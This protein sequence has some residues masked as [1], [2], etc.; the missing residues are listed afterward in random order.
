MTRL[1]PPIAAVAA[2][3]LFVSL[4]M[5]QLDRAAQKE[6]L[7]SLYANDAPARNLADVDEPLQFERVRAQGVL[8]A[9]RQIL[10]DYYVITPL[11]FRRDEPLLLVNRGWIERMAYESGAVELDLDA[12]RR[13]LA[14]RIGNLP[15]AG[16]Q[17]G[18]A[19]MDA[20]SD[21]PKIGV[22]PTTEEVAAELGREILP[23]IV[24]LSPDESFGFDRDWSPDGMGPMTHY[25]YA[26]QWF[27]MAL[28]VVLIAVWQWRKA[29]IAA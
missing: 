1:A 3:A 11:E 29:R 21:W 5:W 4:G 2:I 9:D 22:Y 16:L 12:D 7:E 23:Y 6:A 18:N 8:I 14:G 25:G 13:E 24:L 20:G 15:R 27:A 19:F 28:A 26:F 17:R 10:I